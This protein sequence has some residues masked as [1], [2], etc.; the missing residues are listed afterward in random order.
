ML[1]CYGNVLC[2]HCE[3]GI[4]ALCRVPMCRRIRYVQGSMFG[5]GYSAGAFCIV[6]LNKPIFFVDFVESCLHLEL[7]GTGQKPNCHICTIVQFPQQGRCSLYGL[8][9]A[10][11]SRSSLAETEAADSY[12][13]PGENEG[14]GNVEGGHPTQRMSSFVC[15]SSARWDRK[16][17]S[18]Y[19]STRLWFV[20]IVLC[21]FVNI[22]L[23]GADW[24]CLDM[25]NM[26]VAIR[27]A[28]S[29]WSHD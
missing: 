29:R 11:Q 27:W 13:S 14:A 28:M 5:W 9:T 1:S 3:N 6:L 26:G 8:F 16:A 21:L 25:L 10:G 15:D 20:T 18:F 12:R 19:C 22:L 23:R 24:H 17:R 2:S 4:P 7:Y